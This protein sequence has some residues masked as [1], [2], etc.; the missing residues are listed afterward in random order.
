MK[1]LLEIDDSSKTGRHLLL[2]LKEL[3]RSDKGIDFLSAEE[4]EDKIMAKLIR[5]GIK[6]GV[7][8]KKRVL[9]KLGIK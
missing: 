4:S 6:S 8:P 9:A 1:H 7:A 2:L 3:S 5:E